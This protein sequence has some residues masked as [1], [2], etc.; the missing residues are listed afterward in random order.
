L[1]VLRLP[2]A[3][4]T[5]AGFLPSAAGLSFKIDFQG[6]L[7]RRDDLE[8]VFAD[9]PLGAAVMAL[10]RFAPGPE[11]RIDLDRLSSPEEFPRKP[12]FSDRHARGV[13]RGNHGDKSFADKPFRH[14]QFPFG[15][16]GE[17]GFR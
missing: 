9:I 17:G 13:T 14:D 3:E 6:V 16:T 2:D 5:P 15:P 1:I 11:N 10:S 12:G 8:P 4:E 7:R